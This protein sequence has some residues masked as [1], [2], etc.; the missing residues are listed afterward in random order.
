MAEDKVVDMADVIRERMRAQEALP[1]ATP[2]PVNGG[3]EPVPPPRSFAFHLKDGMVLNFTGYLIVS[4]VFMGC[5]TLE[6]IITGCVPM[7][8]VNYVVEVDDTPP[9]AVAA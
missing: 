7:E 8:N 9:A 5:G 2:R 3:S 6:G 1:K 4:S